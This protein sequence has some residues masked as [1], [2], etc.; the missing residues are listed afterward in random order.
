M[1]IP[2]KMNQIWLVIYMS[3]PVRAFKQ[4]AG[5]AIFFIDGFGIA[6]KCVLDALSYGIF[7]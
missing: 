1:N 4:G 7:V 3:S 6:I 2:A 5:S